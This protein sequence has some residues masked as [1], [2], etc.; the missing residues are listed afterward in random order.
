MSKH[1]T[2]SVDLFTAEEHA[3]LARWFDV[4]PPGDAKS[5][6]VESVIRRLGFTEQPGYRTLVDVA[7]AFIVLENTEARLPQWSASRGEEIVFGRK[8]RDRETVPDRKVL[9]GVEINPDVRGEEMM[10]FS[11]KK[12]ATQ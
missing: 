9:L 12:G 6:A 5:I 7:V 3:I 10:V 2:G 4:E 8:Y 11:Q 1:I